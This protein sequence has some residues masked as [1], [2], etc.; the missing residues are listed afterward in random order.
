MKMFQ[1]MKKLD[2]IMESKELKER[3]AQIGEENLTHALKLLLVLELSEVVK[4][5]ELKH[6]TEDDI[7][8][9]YKITIA[10]R[11]GL[12]ELQDLIT[13][14]A[15]EQWGDKEKA[16]CDYALDVCARLLA[17]E[18][19][20]ENKELGTIPKKIKK[21]AGVLEVEDRVQAKEIE[22]EAE[23]PLIETHTTKDTAMGRRMGKFKKAFKSGGA[24]TLLIFTVLATLATWL[25]SLVG[26]YG[27]YGLGGL[28]FGIFVPAIAQTLFPFLFW[29]E[30]HFWP[31]LYIALYVLSWAFWI[32]FMILLSK[33][34]DE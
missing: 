20:L 12:K 34:E 2:K 1:K 19:S 25:L 3:F 24:I 6:V 4:L 15:E 18:I 5:L 14:M 8:D 16:L 11:Y 33:L 23:N 21:G 29:W 28:L 10:T 27:L 32:G 13:N 9:T 26:Y 30:M 17:L 31:W 22:V 7:L